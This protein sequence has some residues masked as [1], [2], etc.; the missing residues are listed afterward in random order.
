MTST[1][2]VRRILKRFRAGIEA[3]I[4]ISQEVLRLRL[5]RCTW[6]GLPHFR[7]YARCSTVAHN[8]LTLARVLITRTKPA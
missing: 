3:T 2:R 6:T 5:T 4:L 8:L 7:A 1:P